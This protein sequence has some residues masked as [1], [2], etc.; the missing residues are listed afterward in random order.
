MNLW[1]LMEERPKITVLKQI[2]NKFA[3]NRNYFAFVD[4]LRVLPVLENGK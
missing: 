1:I 2:L 3:S 4:N